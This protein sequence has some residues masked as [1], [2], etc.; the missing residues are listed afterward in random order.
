MINGIERERKKH[1]NKDLPKRE[2]EYFYEL[3]YILGERGDDKSIDQLKKLITDK[4]YKISPKET[5]FRRVVVALGIGRN[6][7]GF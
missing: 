3:V 6:P 2:R 4:K 1:L 5:E 7:I